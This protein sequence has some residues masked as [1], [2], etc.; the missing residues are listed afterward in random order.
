VLAEIRKTDIKYLFLECNT[1]CSLKKKRENNI[2]H[3]SASP[4]FLFTSNTEVA[5]HK[6]TLLPFYLIKGCCALEY[7]CPQF[8][9]IKF[10]D[11]KNDIKFDIYSQIL[12]FS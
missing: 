10:L 3:E 1:V 8:F 9:A 4:I 5:D 2:L 11:L 7:I 6:K 12:V